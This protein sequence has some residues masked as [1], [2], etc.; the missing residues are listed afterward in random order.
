MLGSLL[1]KSAEINPAGK[2]SPWSLTETILAR[3][4]N[5]VIPVKYETRNFVLFDESI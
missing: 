3:F 2:L 1:D 4:G 5:L